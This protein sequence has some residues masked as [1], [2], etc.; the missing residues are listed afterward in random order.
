MKTDNFD[1]IELWRQAMVDHTGNIPKRL[2]D[3][4]KEEAF[5]LRGLKGKNNIKRTLM[6]NLC[7]KSY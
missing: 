3:D 7:N 5:G 2:N 6:Q 1:Y 4:A